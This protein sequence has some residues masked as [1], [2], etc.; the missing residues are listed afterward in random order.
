MALYRKFRPQEFHDV[1]GQDHIVTALKNQIRT[2]RIGHAYLFTGTRGTGKTTVAKILARAVNCEH[3]NEDGSPCNECETCKHILSGNSMNVIEID[4]ASNNGVDNIRD[5]IEE[6][7]YPPTEGKYKVYIIDE[8]HMLSKPAF[9]ALLKTLEEPPSYVIFVLATTEV[10]MVPITILSRCQRYD[11]HRITID[12]IAAR[13]RELMDAEGIEIEDKAIR[14][15]AKCADG[16]M[17]DGLS[18]LD[19][20]I[21]FYMNQKITYDGVLQ[22][23]G[24]VDNEIFQ[25]LLGNIRSKNTVGAISII[26]DVVN[27]GRELTQFVNDFVWYMRNLLLAK[28][29]ENAEDVLEMSTENYRQLKET[30][31]KIEDQILTRYIRILSELSNDMKYSSQKRIL[32]EV[33][34]I[35]MC[36][37]QME[38]DMDSLIERIDDLEK[39]VENGLAIAPQLASTQ[40][41]SEGHEK[42]APIKKAMIPDATPEEVKRVAEGWRGL[43]DRVRD[44]LVKEYMSRFYVTVNEEGKLHL[45]LDISEPNAYMAATWFIDDKEHAEEHQAKLREMINDY[46]GAQVP[47]VFDKNETGKSSSDL[48]EDA[49]SKF[50][51]EHNLDVIEEEE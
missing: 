47:V 46:A 25:K 48:Y 8:V 51:S 12:T 34:I 16:S 23:L 42:K 24:A 31:D 44:G 6:V 50:A 4:A 35:R 11:F 7:S 32:L 36:R 28:S 14:Y 20:C 45:I 3:P 13:M 17:R 37:P 27:E 43:V 9:N 38:Q 26:E 10:Q 40:A 39:Q 29:M 30:A 22:Q 19:Q 41:V 2:E 33:A 5:I 1:K 18:L 21:A 15:I 49:I